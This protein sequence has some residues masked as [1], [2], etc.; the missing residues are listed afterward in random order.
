MN[1][2]LNNINENNV[3]NWSGSIEDLLKQKFEGTQKISFICEK[4]KNPHVVSFS[5]IKKTKK[6]ICGSCLRKNGTFA[7]KT[8]KTSEERYGVRNY[9]C[10][11]EGKRRQ[12]EINQRKFGVDYYFQTEEYKEKSVKTN[13]ERYG[14]DNHAKLHFSEKQRNILFNKENFITFIESHENKNTPKLA[15]ELG[16]GNTTFR[17][18]INKYDLTDSYNWQGETSQGELELQDYIKSIGLK[19]TEHRRSIIYPYELDLFFKR[20]NIAIEFNGTYWHADWKKPINYHSMK[21]QMCE[22][23]GIRLIHIFEYEWE[24]N[25]EKIKNYLKDLFCPKTLKTVKNTFVKETSYKEAYSFIEENDLEN[26]NNFDIAVGLYNEE[27]NLISIITFLKKEESSWQIIN[28]T[29]KFG[30]QIKDNYKK[31]LTFFENKYMPNIIN[32]FCDR[33]KYS[34]ELYENLGFSLQEITEPDYVWVNTYK[35]KVFKSD[36]KIDILPKGFDEDKFMRDSNY[37]KI[38]DSGKFS[39]KKVLNKEEN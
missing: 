12:R 32:T 3:I 18:Y 27:D 10:T 23:K 6:F 5:R 29:T 11:E 9:S 35:R 34:K 24:F 33:C 20:F 31:I 2:A 1:I 14:V 16:I 21:S 22:E 17:R 15:K 8:R 13:M 26:F 19:F 39:F 28:I 4:C 36:S 25:K 7:E 30:Y 38:Y 37:F